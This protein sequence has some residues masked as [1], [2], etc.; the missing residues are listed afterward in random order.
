MKLKIALG[1]AVALACL[2]SPAMA[3]QTIKHAW[4]YDKT[5]LGATI[6]DP[7]DLQICTQNCALAP[8]LT[9]NGP[10]V[11]GFEGLTQYNT[12]AFNRNFIP[13]DTMGAVG[14]TQY[15][16]TLNGAIGV[17][18]K[19]TGAQQAIM[20]DVAFWAGAGQTGTNGDPRV[21]Y[22]A[23]AGRWITLAFGA[24]AKDIQIAVSD[25]SDA[26]GGWKSVK[27]EGFPGFGFGAT[28][29]Y[30]T[31]ALDSNA[32]YIGTNDF[33]PLSQGGANNFRGTTLNIIPIDSLFNG[34][35]PTITNMK[36]FRTAYTGGGSDDDRGFALQGVNSATGGTSGTV[37]AASLFDYDTISYSVDN[38]TSGSATAANLGAVR[39]AG[40]SA[41]TT[42]GPGRQPA[43][44]NPANRR[45][46]ATLDERISSSVY[47]W[48]GKL[49]AVH[50][51]NNLNNGDADGDFARVRVMVIDKATG[52]MVDE[53]DIGTG[54][55]DYYQGSLAV[56]AS[57]Q[58]VVGF[59]RSGL[60]PQDGKIGFYAQI[61]KLA[62]DGTIS[63]SGGEILLK[64][65]LTD[66]Y[67][68][69][70]LFGQNA[71][72]RQRWGDYSQVNVDPTN[73]QRF[74]LIGE[75]AREYNLPQFG[76]P[77]GTGGSRWGTWVAVV[78]AGP[79][80]VPE[81]ATWL[82]LIVGFGMVGGAM[83][84]KVRKT[85]ITYA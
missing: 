44:A 61:L 15:M 35:A 11:L 38:L 7:N 18:D 40:E 42:A 29:D 33:A 46:I 56:N 64:E 71:A 32:V 8:N 69:G 50:T 43:A 85:V 24:N 74:Y 58:V 16:I 66:D 45:I 54:Q 63:A 17:Y 22:N 77:G 37:V 14:A 75:F 3:A 55:Y 27:F 80:G 21:M 67:H 9:P 57:G 84:R 79:G 72:G 76:H 19:M 4:W 70:S 25:T 31:L 73:N 26:L 13:P 23:A 41:F 81:P 78:D 20:S 48:N 47:E 68:N 82:M 62:P 1:A 65:S 83:R 28:A 2:S 34:G 36:Q 49:I 6:K 30:P 12:A 10:V 51:V 39:F 53:Y 59:N 52:A 60:S 5:V